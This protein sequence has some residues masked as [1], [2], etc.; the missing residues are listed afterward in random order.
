[1][2]KWVQEKVPL[3]SFSSLQIFTPHDKRNIVSC[4]PVKILL[5]ILPKISTEN[6]FNIINIFCV[7]EIQ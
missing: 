7:Y 1:M 5:N 3:C 6:N 2:N 4:F